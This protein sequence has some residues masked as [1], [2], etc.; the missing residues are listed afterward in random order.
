MGNMR[1]TITFKQL[2][3]IS[4]VMT[5]TSASA[6]IY[7]YVDKHGRVTLTDNPTNDDF[8]RLVKTWKGWEEA[9]SSIALKDYKKNKN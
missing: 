7:K 2:L 8:K 9:K 4:L 3:L 6:D 5:A 1:M